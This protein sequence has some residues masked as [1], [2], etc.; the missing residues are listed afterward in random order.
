[1][2]KFKVGDKVR[3]V[4]DEKRLKKIYINDV[5]Y[6]AA[7]GVIVA[8]CDSND[9]D[10]H[11]IQVS[12]DNNRFRWFEKQDLEL[13]ELQQDEFRV[14]ETDDTC[15]TWTVA[16]GPDCKSSNKYIHNDGTVGHCVSYTTKAE[17]QVALDLYLE[18]QPE[19]T[20]VGH[21]DRGLEVEDILPGEMSLERFDILVDY[22][23]EKRIKVVMCT[24]STEYAQGTNKLHNFDRA[25]K[26]RGITPM[27][28]L[29]GMK[30]KHE[31]SIQDML[32]GLK[33]GKTY[34]RKV[35]EEKFTDNINYQILEWAILA[36]DNGWDQPVNRTTPVKGDY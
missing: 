33:D 2:N 28:A 15:N 6:R 5:F 8:I 34:P 3:V 9:C 1:M 17:A 24:K 13:I 7:K 36:R 11:T 20:F 26:M 27:E 31:V 22:I 35:W 23:V 12:F 29:R 25:G 18:K 21:P 32:D 14:R 19:Q 16:N 30:L 4:A 10:P